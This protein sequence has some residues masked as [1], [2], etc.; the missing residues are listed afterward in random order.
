MR[1]GTFS[2][3]SIGLFLNICRYIITNG[4]VLVSLAKKKM[5]ILLRVEATAHSSYHIR[6][7]FKSVYEIIVLLILFG[8]DQIRSSWNVGNSTVQESSWQWG[9]NYYNYQP[10]ILAAIQFFAW[11]VDITLKRTK[12]AHLCYLILSHISATLRMRPLKGSRL[13]PAMRVPYI[14]IYIYI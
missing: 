10:K 3:I 11:K 14:Y 7:F 1:L 8:V 5:G 12:H 6:Y 4:I 9:I 2:K 13:T